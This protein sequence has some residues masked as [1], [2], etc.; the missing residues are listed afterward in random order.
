VAERAERAGHRLRLLVEFLCPDEK[1][2]A[3]T[4]AMINSDS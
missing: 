3:H 2:G 1:N 4:C